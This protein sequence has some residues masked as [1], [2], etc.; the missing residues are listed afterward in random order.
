MKDNNIFLF[1][2]YFNK[3]LIKYIILYGKLKSSAKYV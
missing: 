1:E 2:Y 3:V